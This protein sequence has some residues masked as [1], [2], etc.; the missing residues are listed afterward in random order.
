M[1]NMKIE[2]FEPM[3]PPTITAQERKVNFKTRR[4][5]DPPE[6]K[7]AKLKLESRLARHSPDE[8]IIGPAELMVMWLF[9]IKGDARSGDWKPTRPDT[10]NLQKALKDIMTKLGFWRD[11]ALVCREVIEKRYSDKPGLYIVIEEL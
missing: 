2:F 7:A 5:Y 8:P 6:L 11:D 9:P 4:F 1:E 10:D 3:I